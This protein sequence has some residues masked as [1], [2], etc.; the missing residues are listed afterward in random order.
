MHLFKFIILII[1]PFK[2]QSDRFPYPF[3]YFNPRNPFIYLKGE[4]LSLLEMPAD[5]GHDRGY[6]PQGTDDTPLLYLETLLLPNST[7]TVCAPLDLNLFKALARICIMRCQNSLS[8][9]FQ[10][11]AMHNWWRNCW[12]VILNWLLWR[13][14]QSAPLP[15]PLS[16]K[17]ECLMIFKVTVVPS[18]AKLLLES[19][20]GKLYFPLWSWQNV[21]MLKG[22]VC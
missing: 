1:G 21:I 7:W 15:S 18:S 11:S 20:E 3:K 6:N 9:S 16:S 14:K 17:L 19:G 2:D 5:I 10:T 13:T 4:K 8:P 12:D 22:K